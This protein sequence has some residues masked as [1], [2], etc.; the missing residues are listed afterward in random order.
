MEQEMQTLTKKYGTQ[1]LE[2]FQQTD[3]FTSSV[4]KFKYVH[5]KY[6]QARDLMMKL[7]ENPDY[8]NESV[9]LAEKFNVTKN[10]PEYIQEYNQLI[11][12]YIPEYADYQNEL[13][14]VG[15]PQ[16]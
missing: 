7:N 2:K 13:K 12:R 15:N 16:Q 3:T 11:T 10:S 14:A 5:D 8:I 9:L 4:E 6:S 1:A